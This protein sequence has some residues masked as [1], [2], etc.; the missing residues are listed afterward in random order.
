MVTL[1]ARNDIIKV[2]DGCD[3]EERHLHIC[4]HSNFVSSE[5]VSARLFNA[6]WECP[7]SRGRATDAREKESP[8]LVYNPKVEGRNIKIAQDLTETNLSSWKWSKVALHERYLCDP[9]K[10]EIDPVRTKDET[11]GKRCGLGGCARLHKIPGKSLSATG[12][13]SPVEEV[14]VCVRGPQS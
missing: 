4:A 12:G 9:E 2:N 1:D 6:A 13:G 3:C 8:L 14:R 5:H 10:T 7:P 11:E